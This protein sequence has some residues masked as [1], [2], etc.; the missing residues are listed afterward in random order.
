MVD[1]D[2]TDPL[3]KNLNDV[4]QKVKE[5]NT[6]IDELWEE[7]D[8]IAEIEVVETPDVPSFISTRTFQRKILLL[9]KFSKVINIT[10]G[11]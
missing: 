3:V 2:F 6:I 9:E 1:I 5:L 7:Y 11:I 4:Q 10:G 8:I